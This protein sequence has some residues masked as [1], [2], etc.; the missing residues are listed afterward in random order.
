MSRMSPAFPHAIPD[1]SWIISSA[2]R[3]I[4]TRSPAIAITDA[5]EAASAS[6]VTLTVARWR[7]SAF[8]MAMPSQASPPGLLM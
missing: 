2:P 6:T 4:V 5:A 3:F 1:A 7:R 8:M